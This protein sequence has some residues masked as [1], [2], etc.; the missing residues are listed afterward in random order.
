MFWNNDYPPPR[1]VKPT[2]IARDPAKS[3]SDVLDRLAGKVMLILF[4]S[5]LRKGLHALDDA[6]LA[7]RAYAMAHAMMEERTKRENKMGA[8]TAWYQCKACGDQ[9]TGDGYTTV[10]HC[11]NADEN[12]TTYAEPDSGPIY[13]KSEES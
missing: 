5:N 11:P 12:D 10:R 6:D 8:E 1:K 2:W 7:K 13:C 9:M 3:N 4:K